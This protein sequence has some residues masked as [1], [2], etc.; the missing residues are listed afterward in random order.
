MLPFLPHLS[1][2]VYFK[3]ILYNFTRKSKTKTGT[4]PLF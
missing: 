3:L 2:N 1:F 4:N